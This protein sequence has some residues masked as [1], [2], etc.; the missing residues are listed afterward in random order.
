M[1]LDPCPPGMD[2][3]WVDAV[4]P[5]LRC[6]AKERVCMLL[7]ASS[8]ASAAG[9]TASAQVVLLSRWCSGGGAQ[10]VLSWWCSVGGAQ[11]VV[12]SWWCSVGGA[13]VVLPAV[14]TSDSRHQG[15]TDG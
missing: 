2:D 6:V 9:A 14:T 15:S 8:A 13:Q 7:H 3:W 4:P 5:S 10:L 1:G 12:L 11:L